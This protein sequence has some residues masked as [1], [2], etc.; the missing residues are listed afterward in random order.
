MDAKQLYYQDATGDIYE[1]EADTAGGI[2]G[3]FRHLATDE[4]VR[5]KWSSLRPMATDDVIALAKAG[6]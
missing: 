6:A 2:W 3:W 1:A 5:M 4:S